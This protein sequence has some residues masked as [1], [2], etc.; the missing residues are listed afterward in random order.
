MDCFI[1]NFAEIVSLTLLLESFRNNGRFKDLQ[2]K[3]GISRSSH[4]THIA[5]LLTP[6]V[7][8]FQDRCPTHTSIEQQLLRPSLHVLHSSTYA[9]EESLSP[10]HSGALSLGLSRACRSSCLYR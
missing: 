2:T 7:N 8:M 6:S 5:S 3:T 1:L 4:M 9:L 10:L